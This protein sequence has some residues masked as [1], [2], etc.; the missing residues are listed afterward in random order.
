MVGL[1]RG[2]KQQISDRNLL[3][4]V[5]AWGKRSSEE[6]GFKEAVRFVQGLDFEFLKIHKIKKQWCFLFVFF[7]CFDYQK[8]RDKARLLYDFP[9]S[10][11]LEIQPYR[12]D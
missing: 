10:S 3:F 8:P 4:R 9:D 2:E 1:K 11:V 6:S 7:V 5:P 12:A